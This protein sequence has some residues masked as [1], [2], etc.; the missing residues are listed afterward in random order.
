MKLFELMETSPDSST[1][2]R[3]TYAAV[4]FS[5]ATID[6]V[7]KYIKDNEI[8]NSV[9]GSKLHTTLLYSRKYCPD[10]KAQ[11]EI[12][13]PWI[14]VPQG[15]D[16][17]QTQGKLRN[18]PKKNCLVVKFKCP[19]LTARHKE[20]MKEHDASYDFPDYTPHITLS[21]DIGD[22]NPDDLPDVKEAIGDIEI[23]TEYGEDLDLN[24]ADKSKKDD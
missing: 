13:P 1:D 5:E 11:G 17:W 3:G 16:V 2:K 9:A 18:E 12:N 8:P 10:Y 23:V 7:L 14:G 4:K 20:L 24:W 15:F 6:A 19:E 21:Y 22:M